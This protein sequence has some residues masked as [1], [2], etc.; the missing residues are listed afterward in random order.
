[1]IS[2]TPELRSQAI[3]FLMKKLAYA[4]ACG[5]QYE[6]LD[7]FLSE[8]SD[9]IRSDHIEQAIINALYEWDL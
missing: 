4:D 6:F 8:V 2:D 7:T 1:M 9:D 5:L 3:I